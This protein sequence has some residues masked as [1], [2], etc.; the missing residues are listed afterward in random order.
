MRRAARVDDNHAEIVS[1]LRKAGCSVLSLATIGHGA[2]DI[3]VGRAG[4]CYALEIKDGSKPPSARRLTDDEWKFRDAW[5][6]H[7]AVVESVE[8]ALEAIR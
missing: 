2:P 7:Y 3:L 6:G 1:A 8:Q 5:R 4:R